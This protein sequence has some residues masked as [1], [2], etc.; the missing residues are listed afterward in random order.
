MAESIAGSFTFELLSDKIKESG[1]QYDTDKIRKAYELANSFHAGQK[2]DSGEDYITHPIAVSCILTELGMD[3]DTICAG[4]LHDVV[5]D[6]S[7]TLEDLTKQFGEGVALLVD[8]VT[9]LRK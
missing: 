8:G 7:C 6:T 2:R 1:K 9:K 3:T 4:L 5:E